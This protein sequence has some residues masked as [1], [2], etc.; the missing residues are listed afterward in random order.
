MTLHSG[1]DKLLRRSRPAR[2]NHQGRTQDAGSRGDCGDHLRKSAVITRPLGLGNETYVV[3]ARTIRV[4]QAIPA[5]DR[6]RLPRGNKPLRCDPRPT[7]AIQVQGRTNARGDGVKSSSRA[8]KGRD[9][10]APSRP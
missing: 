7:A 2:R 3:D 6:P 9:R 4:N 8:S 1:R 5:R 10:E